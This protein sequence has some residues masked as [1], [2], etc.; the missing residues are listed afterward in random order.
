MKTRV[1]FTPVEKLDLQ[2]LSILAKSLLARIVVDEN[3]N[4]E[5]E[6]PLKVHS[7][8]PGNVTFIRPESFSGI[9]DFLQAKN[10]QPYFVETGMVTGPRS[11]ASSHREIARKHGFTRLPFVIADG[12]DGE[13]SVDIPV[14]NGRHFTVAKIARGLSNRRQ[15]IVLSHF[16]GHC[17][18]GFGA[19]IKMLGIGF[20]SR[21]GKIIVHTIK[22]C[23]ND[24]TI[25]WDDSSKL[26]W[27]DTLSERVAE[28]AQAA[29]AGKKNIYFNFAVNITDNCDCD[30]KKMVPVY[31]HLGIFVS[32]DPLSVDKACFDMLAKRENQPRPFS[33]DA[34]FEYGRRLN[35]G[36]LDY[37]LIKLS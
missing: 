36:S 20:A 34:I 7:G 6:I 16:K 26:Y 31:D 24:P 28:Y 35:L 30:G 22:E 4:L 15:V 17:A 27:G 3:I 11:I 10:I 29:I 32:T 33:G 25:N 18:T 21:R 1:Y 5:A 12:E 8:Q 9:I 37:E 19:T 13:E 23:H 14:R 2:A